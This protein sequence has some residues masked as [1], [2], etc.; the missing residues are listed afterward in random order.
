MAARTNMP[1]DDRLA[2]V[3]QMLSPQRQYGE[4]TALAQQYEIS[5]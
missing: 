5:R 1:V 3:N 4:A 2:I